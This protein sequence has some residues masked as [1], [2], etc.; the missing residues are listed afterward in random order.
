MPPAPPKSDPTMTQQFVPPKTCQTRPKKG[1]PRAS[2]GFPFGNKIGKIQQ[3]QIFQEARW[4]TL[5]TTRFTRCSRDSLQS[6]NLCPPAGGRNIFAFPSVSPE[7]L[8][9][10]LKC[11]L[12]APFWQPKRA[13]CLLK[14]ASKKNLR[15]FRCLESLKWTL[16]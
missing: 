13:N 5:C 3:Q 8:K 10:D 14:G 16:K 9:M 7:S 15:I 11:S 12:S 2:N 4:K 6:S 1:C